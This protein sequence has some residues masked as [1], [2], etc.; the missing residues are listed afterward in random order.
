[1]SW[2]SNTAILHA[3]FGTVALVTFWLAGMSKKGSPL[4]K[5]AGKLY[6]LTM[7]AIILTGTPMSIYLTLYKNTAT[8]AFFCYLLLITATSVWNAWRAIRDKQNWQH[9]IGPIYHLLMVLNLIAAGSIIAVALMIPNDAQIILI[10]F[11]TIGF[12]NAINMFRFSRKPPTDA[13]WWLGQHMNAMVGNGVATHI[14]FL[15][16]GLPKLLPMLS[17]PLL[18]NLAWLGPLSLSFIA[19][20]YLKRK[21]LPK[22]A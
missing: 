13:R 7:A 12:L 21:Y 20:V 1:M 19:G 14:A 5:R 11:S 3:S 6:L 16:I 15:S 22:R 10:A 17:G 9:F 2:Y 8:G 18:Q 4:H